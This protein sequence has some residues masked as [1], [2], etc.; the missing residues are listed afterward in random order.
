MNIFTPVSKTF[1]TAAHLSPPFFPDHPTHFPRRGRRFSPP[2]P[3]TTPTHRRPHSPTNPRDGTSHT[4]LSANTPPLSCRHTYPRADT[5]LSADHLFHAPAPH[6]TAP[7]SCLNSALHRVVICRPATH[8]AHFPNHTYIYTTP[9]TTHFLTC[10]PLLQP[11]AEGLSPL[12]PRSDFRAVPLPQ[13][14]E[15]SD[16]MNTYL[17]IMTSKSNKTTLFSPVSNN[18]LSNSPFYVCKIIR[19]FNISPDFL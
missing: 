17:V 7:P 19:I 8:T 16:F 11:L 9:T 18:N 15:F 6:A 12:F 2:T 5:P 10:H 1:P 14:S 13:T 4:L 3:P